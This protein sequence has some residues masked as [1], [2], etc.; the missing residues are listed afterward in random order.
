MQFGAQIIWVYPPLHPPKNPSGKL[1]KDTIYGDKVNFIKKRFVF[2]PY[3]RK[4]SNRFIA[5]NCNEFCYAKS[6]DLIQPRK[7]RAQF[8]KSGPE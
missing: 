7:P 2:E 1:K 8:D 5:K 6:R 3:Q 4:S